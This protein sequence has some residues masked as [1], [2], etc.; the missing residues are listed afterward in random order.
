M[1][2]GSDTPHFRLAGG[3]L[4]PPPPGLPPEGPYPVFQL[5]ALPVPLRLTRTPVEV[6]VPVIGFGHLNLPVDPGAVRPG[7]GPTG[8]ATVTGR[9]AGRSW[10]ASESDFKFKLHFSDTVVRRVA[11]VD[12]GH[13]PGSL[14]RTAVVSE[15]APSSPTRMPLDVLGR[16]L[17]IL[18][19][20]ELVCE[21]DVAS[22]LEPA[23]ELQG[24]R[25]FEAGAGQLELARELQGGQRLG[26]GAGAR[27][28]ARAPPPTTFRIHA[29][30][31]V[32]S[33]C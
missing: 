8:R 28:S 13:G 16:V 18:L 27:R 24:K 9:G 6:P 11:L 7:V 12:P 22:E 1:W 30:H 3:A 25:S 4:A 32:A 29:F 19:E 15:A 10:S 2:V 14:T 20:L 26:V 33:W 31:A 17:S 23:R 21:L 5:L